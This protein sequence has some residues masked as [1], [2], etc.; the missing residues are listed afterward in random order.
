[1]L[2]CD[3]DTFDVVSVTSKEL[4]LSGKEVYDDI[5]IVMEL[6]FKKI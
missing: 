4:V 1:M 5:T 2:L 6:H 3:V